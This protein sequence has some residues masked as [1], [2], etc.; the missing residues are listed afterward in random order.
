MRHGAGLPHAAPSLTPGSPEASG[1]GLSTPLSSPIVNVTSIVEKMNSDRQQIGVNP[2]RLSCEI[3]SLALDRAAFV[4][5]TRRSDRTP[6]RRLCQL[7]RSSVAGE[8]VVQGRIWSDLHQISM[9]ELPW[10]RRNA[11]STRY[12]EIGVAVMRS[13]DDD[14]FYMVQY[15]RG[16]DEV[17]NE[18]D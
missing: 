16:S 7:L 2:L 11:L 6:R 12:T 15:F 14:G 9:K 18:S 17:T 4:A 5:Q 13:I 8:N 1:C 3:S 10:Y